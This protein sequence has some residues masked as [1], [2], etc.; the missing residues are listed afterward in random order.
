[1][2][3]Q[4]SKIEVKLL[5]S[6]SGKV[7][8]LESGPDFVELLISLMNTPLGGLLDTTQK[9]VE[10][11]DVHALVSLK[12]SLSNLG[13]QSFVPGKTSSAAIPAARSTDQLMGRAA[14]AVYCSNCGQ[15]RIPNGNFCTSCGYAGYLQQTQPQEPNLKDNCKFMVTD[16]LDVFESSTIMAIELMKEHVEDFRN[17]KTSTETVTEKCVKKLI[18]CSILG[19]QDVL[20]QIFPDADGQ[21]T[22]ETQETESSIGSIGSFEPVDQPEF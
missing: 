3:P 11:D 7:I 22:K 12:T 5:R 4:N 20:T 15:T 18:L 6:R 21:E 10:T 9:S 1:M 2:A 16:S 13:S 17:I 8:F 19:C 14:C